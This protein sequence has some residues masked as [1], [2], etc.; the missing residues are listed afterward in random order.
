VSRIA[1]C[2]PVSVSARIASKNSSLVGRCFQPAQLLV[3][4]CVH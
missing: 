3:S 4:R 2:R 1:F